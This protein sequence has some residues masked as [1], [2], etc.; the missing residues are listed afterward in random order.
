MNSPNDLISVEE[1]R[2]ILRETQEPPHDPERDCWTDPA[3]ANMAHTVIA[4]AEQIKKLHDAVDGL[5]YMAES[6]MHIADTTATAAGLSHLI[7]AD[8]DGDWQTIW[9]R[10]WGKLEEHK[11]KDAQIKRLQAFSSVLMAKLGIY[12]FADEVT[13]SL[14]LL[15]EGD[16]GKG[17]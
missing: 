12:G 4:Q 16:L 5:K 13:G 2:H 6:S 17:K 8:G 11:A 14:D 3:M 9:E 1:A 10:V 7:D 15:R